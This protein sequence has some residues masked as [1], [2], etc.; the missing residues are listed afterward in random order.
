MGHVL[1]HSGP[2][3]RF[4]I[5]SI[6]RGM[7]W[8]SA[9]APFHAPTPQVLVGGVG[10][11]GPRTEEVRLVFRA[12]GGALEG[13][14]RDGDGKPVTNAQVLVG[15]EIDFMKPGELD[16]IPLPDGSEAYLPS[17][18]RV[19]ADG[20]GRFRFAGVP[21]GRQPVGVRAPGFG[22]WNGETEIREG[23]LAQ[24]EIVLLPGTTVEGTLSDAAGNPIEKLPIVLAGECAFRHHSAYSAAD[25]SFALHDL[26]A[27]EFE[28]VVFKDGAP[29][30]VS[31]HLVGSPGAVLRWD[32]VLGGGLV[33]RGRIAA[34]G[35]DPTR[36]MIQCTGSA[37]AQGMLHVDTAEPDAGGLFEFP[38]CADVPHRLEV[39]SSEQPSYPLV[40][41]EHVLPAGQELVIEIDPALWP[42]ARFKGR[43]LDAAGEP[44]AE[45]HVRLKGE[46]SVAMG[47]LWP[48]DPTGAFDIGPYPPGRWRIQ[49]WRLGSSKPLFV[50]DEVQVGAGETFDFGDLVVE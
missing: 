49:V 31:A 2:D 7:V 20:E 3:G 50:T 10:K 34:G 44:L 5:R 22:Q 11:E 14:L 9:R 28:L 41:L 16:P 39:S 36:F 27:G 32:P 12:R 25:G 23:E 8:L 30:T 29:T 6:S 45:A 47:L 19:T 21:A 17:A 24:M 46:R 18:Q 42:S 37:N 38:D 15:D 40:V 33:I 43:V 26:P 35:L 4:D 1:A 48:T 13:V